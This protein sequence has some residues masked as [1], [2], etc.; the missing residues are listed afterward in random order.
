MTTPKIAT[1]A[2]AFALCAVLAACGGGGTGSSAGG[3][4]SVVPPAPT[5]TA[6]ATVTPPVDTISGT[7]VEYVSSAPLSGFTVTVGAVPTTSTCLASQ[8]A[9]ANACG[10]PAGTTVTTTTSSTGTFSVT[11]PA[12]G[13]YMLTIGKD[14]TYATLHRT[15]AVAAGANAIGTVKV[16]ALS[17][18]EQNWLV[19]VNNQRATVSVP[20]SF[21]NLQV[22]EFAEEQARKWTA[23]VV[24]G[25]TV[26]S[27]AG[28][29]PYQATYSA[30]PGAMYGAAGALNL[31]GAASQ[32]V[33]SDQIWMA[34]KAN[35]PSGNWQTCTFASNTGHY[36]NISNTNTVWI[37][38]GES[39][40]SFTSSNYPGIGT[41]IWTYDLML[42]ENGGS[43]G[44]ASKARLPVAL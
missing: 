39:N 27:D 20:T 40:T 42:I 10:V 8:T 44:P 35:C 29:A 19:D 37:G 2:S 11:V 16:A 34:E 31:G 36:I 12:T 13:T 7:A 43:S 3:G 14:T 15:V 26:Y 41:Q 23:D 33:I 25:T 6:T 9:S 1:L 28:Y 5:P 24:A 4:G 38:L 32:Y 18:D 30:N 21:A 17:T 22:D